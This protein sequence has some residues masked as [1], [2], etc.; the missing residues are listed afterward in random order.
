[1]KIAKKKFRIIIRQWTPRK[2]PYDL[3]MARVK[4]ILHDAYPK[5]KMVVYVGWARRVYEDKKQII[6]LAATGDTG[7]EARKIF[8]TSEK[9]GEDI[10]VIS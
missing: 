10:W 2:L 5:L 3:P 9:F 8:K 6:Y 1:M 4:E 7:I